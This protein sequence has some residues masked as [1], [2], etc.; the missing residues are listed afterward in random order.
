MTLHAYFPVLSL[1]EIMGTEGLK[2]ISEIESGLRALQEDR[3]LYQETNF[4]NRAQAL[5]FIDFHIIDRI[6]GLLS[7]AE[8]KKELAALK[9]LAEKIKCELEN[10][11]TDLFKLLRENIKTGAYKTNSFK[12][13]VCKYVGYGS[14]DISQPDKIGFDTLD[15][16]INGLLSDQPIPEATI[17]RK[18]DMVFYQKT[19]ARIVF[20]LTVLAKFKHDDVFFDIGS[21]LGQVAVLV[22]LISEII[23]KGVEYEPAYHNYAKACASKLNLPD[24]EF[25]NADARRVNYSQG[26]VFFLYTPFEG[27]MLQEML[28]ILQKES[29]KRTIRIFTYGPCSQQVASQ[30]WLNCL[31]GKGDSHYKLYEFKS[32]RMH[33]L[34]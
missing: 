24:V 19:P 31:N 13:L 20:E 27:R 26:V 12:E 14:D 7:K 6:D 32:G 17:E 1:A 34:L 29:Q 11:D 10:I 2:I 8:W 4:N 3:A 15:I 16:F 30:S 33:E 28:Y 18:P 22:N 23:V 9:R 5:D 21:G 25:I